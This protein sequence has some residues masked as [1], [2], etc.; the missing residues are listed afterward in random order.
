MSA[1]KGQP[2]SKTKRR[3]EDCRAQARNVR[4]IANELQAGY[5]IVECVKGSL[6]GAEL[7]FPQQEALRV[8]M[9]HLW[10]VSEWLSDR[11]AEL[12]LDDEDT[13]QEEGT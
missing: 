13:D 12:P 5:C 2:A 9:R 10:G 6:E 7:G 1:R 8:A 3:A 11:V 4:G